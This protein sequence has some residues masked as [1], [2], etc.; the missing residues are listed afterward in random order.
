MDGRFKHFQ[1]SSLSF[2]GQLTIHPFHFVRTH[3]QQIYNNLG[4][5]TQNRFDFHFTCLQLYLL[6]RIVKADTFTRICCLERYYSGYNIN[7]DFSEDRNIGDINLIYT[8]FDDS[9]LFVSSDFAS[10]HQ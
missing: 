4:Y 8:C 6:F 10:L 9:S 2:F 7:F 1:D 3:E 5:F